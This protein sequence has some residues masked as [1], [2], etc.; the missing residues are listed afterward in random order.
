MP[1][2]SRYRWWKIVVGTVWVCSFCAA[3]YW[4][5]KSGISMRQLP[6][7]VRSVIRSYGAWGP[8]AVL[9]LYVVR[10]Y[11]FL[12]TT[13]L[14]LVSS[15][16]Y[17]PLIGFT[18]A[19]IGDNLTSALGFATGRFMGRRFVS[20]YETAWIRRY[21]E[22]LSHNAFLS[23]LFMRLFYF[24]FDIVNYGCGMFNIPFGRY[25]LATFIGLLPSIVTLVFL[26]DAFV[27]P[28]AFIVFIFLLIA[29]VAL[30][31]AIKNSRLSKRIF[32]ERTPNHDVEKF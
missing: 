24:P 18:L 31:F 22:A 14:I 27:N 6:H 9:A 11:F 5:E 15:S 32:A 17:G 20:D 7:L 2:A 10:T 4:F 3:F 21:D 28:R 29:T 30:G 8:A 1:E 12:P 16:L 25:Q 13:I 26:G 19:V 23:V